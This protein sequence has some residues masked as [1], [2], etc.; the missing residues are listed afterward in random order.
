MGT[1]LLEA[2]FYALP[3]T[4][5]A[6]ST[7]KVIGLFPDVG[8]DLGVLEDVDGS[9]KGCSGEEE[10][11]CEDFEVEHYGC[12]AA[13]SSIFPRFIPKPKQNAGTE[14]HEKI[15]ELLRVSGKSRTV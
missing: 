14:V 12:R 10:C 11:K 13:P 5:G 1:W 9:A 2:R 4:Y 15:S 3:V 6:F 7:L 8:I